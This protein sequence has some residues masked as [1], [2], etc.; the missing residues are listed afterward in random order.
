[1]E[2]CHPV[3]EAMNY[4]LV[5]T[6]QYMSELDKPPKSPGPCVFG[7]KAIDVGPVDYLRRLIEE[8]EALRRNFPERLMSVEWVL[9]SCAP[10]TKEQFD[11]FVAHGYGRRV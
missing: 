1:M 5:T 8:E 11:W 3:L 4:F 6:G 10:I 2:I 9:I 7:T